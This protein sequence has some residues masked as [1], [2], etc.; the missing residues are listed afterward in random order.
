MIESQLFIKLHDTPRHETAVVILNYN[1]EKL[2]AEFLPSVIQ[3]TPHTALII[4]DNGSTDN[5]VEFIQQNFPNIHLLRAKQNWGFA[6]GYNRALA[7]LKK[8]YNFRYYILLNSDVEVT[9][10]WL[11]PL[12]ETLKKQP[13]AVACQPKIKAYQRKTHFEYA[14]AGGGFI[15]YLGYPYCRGRIFDTTEEDKGQYDDTLP[16]FWA[17]GACLAV[18]AKIFHEV[19]GFDG[20]FFAHMEEIDLCWRLKNQNHQIYY[21][22]ESTV[23]HL[24]GGTLQT[25]NPKKMLLNFRNGLVMLLKNLPEKNLFSTLFIRMVLDGLAALHLVSKGKF[26]GI[27][28]VLQAH[29][30]L[31]ANF[32]TLWAK[33][34]A[35][36]AKVMQPH[37]PEIKQQSVVWSYFVKGKKI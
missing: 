10:N 1:G 18:Q 25:D 3:H 28:V 13:Q 14:G 7:L 8:N 6:E 33:R 24:G 22:G 32:S 9:P 16:V 37:H 31:Y 34:K 17:S 15:D 23:Y 27:G 2:L 19:G 5:S 26:W 12:I 30:Y 29:F 36:Q 11:P 20:D 35:E 21:C 4:A